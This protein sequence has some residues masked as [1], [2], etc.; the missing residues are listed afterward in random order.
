MMHTLY[1]NSLLVSL[2]LVLFSGCGDNFDDDSY[3]T[4]FYPQY[5]S[6]RGY[7]IDSGVEGMTYTKSNGSIRQTGQGG[8]FDYYLSETLTFSIGNLIIG[9]SLALSTVTPKDI[10]AF[11]NLELNTS[12]YS[13]EVNNRVRLLIAL[14]SNANPA[15]GI[16]INDSTKAKAINWTTPLYSGS[17]TEFNTALNIATGGDVD[18]SSISSTAASAHFSS[19]LRCSYSG[20]YA[21][22]WLLPNGSRD[23]FV[24]VM[25]QSSGTIV[26]LGDGQDLNGDGNY[27]EFLFARGSHDMDTGEY[28]FN[29]TGVFDESIGSIIPSTKAVSGDGSSDSYDR[30]SGSFTQINPDT[31]ISES[32]S[33]EASRV[34]SGQNTAYRYTGFGYARA[35]G[36]PNPIDPT[37]PSAP[38]DP[39]LGLF[40]FDINRDGTILGL[41]HDART[42][43][44][45]PLIGEINFTSNVID[46]N[47]TYSDGSRYS[48]HGI[49][50]NDGTV[51]LDWYD[52]NSTKLGYIDGVGCQLQVHN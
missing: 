21:G 38:Y 20:A 17:E 45:P 32:G 27:T 23:G 7:F 40:T 2:T 3:A 22:N 5:P 14:D 15:D 26:T 46:M 42:N 35:S 8:S 4:Q 30:V 1:K 29:E 12:L 44:E 6:Q 13:P 47:L 41:I 33:Y 19:S 25:I 50:A 36:T 51:T 24:G 49:L 52:I 16:D 39:I 43:E 10:V 37:D 48:V 11:E 28:D 18:V 34:G 31:N 9:E